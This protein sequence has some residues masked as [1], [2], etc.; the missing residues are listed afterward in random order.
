MF[1]QI[2]SQLKK[3]QKMRFGVR[4]VWLFRFIVF[5]ILTPY[6]VAFGVWGWALITHDQDPWILKMIDYCLLIP[7]KLSAPAVATAALNFVPRVDD[8]DGDGKADVD[9][10]RKDDKNGTVNRLDSIKRDGPGGPG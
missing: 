8:S 10:V 7:E 2:T 4:S 9:E 6:A 1:K 5:L 3:I